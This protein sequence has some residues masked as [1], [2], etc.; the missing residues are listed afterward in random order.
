MR[1]QL[2]FAL[3]IAASP[4]FAQTSELPPPVRL[5]T[6]V[7]GHIHPALGI[8]KKGTLIGIYCK[9]E[10]RPCLM[11]RSTDGGMTWT[12]PEL[13]PHIAKTDIYPGSLTTLS[14]GR[15][16]HAYNVWFKP[17]SGDKK[18]RY[19]AYSISSDDGVTWSEPKNLAKNK[20]E[21][22]HSVI[23]HPFLELAPNQW[24]MSLIDRTLVYDPETGK[25]TTLGD[26]AP[27]G[28]VSIVRTPKG[29]LVSGK[30]LRS[31]D[32]GK[33]WQAV[34]PFPDVS[35]QGWRQELFALKNGQILATQ[36]P[37]PGVGGDKIQFIL[38]H[39]DGVSWAMD[40]PF[41]FYNPNRPIGG[42]ACPKTVQID[43]RTLGTIF[44]DTDAKQ[45]GGNG[46]FFRR[47]P[48]ASLTRK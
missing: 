48:I 31:T 5:E 6:G 26:G 36:T 33:S 39:D 30:G 20:D 24:L 41:E 27:H 25:E 9:N 13:F 21:K 46:V 43:E 29:T 14:D 8:T 32:G 18:S 16:V 37:G 38:S 34:K 12:K 19:V 40:R 28:L 3:F 47:V 11:V 23:R 4:L 35:S 45:D 22:V 17:E 2:T 1:N 15:I 44:Y 42:R 10:Y 7:S